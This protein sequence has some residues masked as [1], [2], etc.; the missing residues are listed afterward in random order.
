L[1][2]KSEKDSFIFGVEANQPFSECT[3]IKNDTSGLHCK[4]QFSSQQYTS[5]PINTCSTGLFNKLA[6]RL[7]F[8]EGEATYSFNCVLELKNLEL[9]GEYFDIFKES[10]LESFSS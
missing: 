4:F 10:F 7:S 2:T 3:L 9:S 1:I 6:E 5:N 8:V